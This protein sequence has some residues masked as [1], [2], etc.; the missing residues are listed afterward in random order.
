MV[1]VSFHKYKLF[2]NVLCNK[3]STNFFIYL[4]V[5]KSYVNHFLSVLFLK[6]LTHF[7]ISQHFIV[8]KNNI[9]GDPY[10]IL[11]CL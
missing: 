5:I 8:K 7:L 4:Y 2:C 6:Y 9:Q 3:T 10:N 11:N 1:N